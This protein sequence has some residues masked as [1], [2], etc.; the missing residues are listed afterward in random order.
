M[1][2]TLERVDTLLKNGQCEQSLQERLRPD[3]DVFRS[4]QHYSVGA[5]QLALKHAQ[6]AYDC[7]PPECLCERGYATLMLALARQMTGDL[8]QARQMVYEGLE[9]ETRH[10]PSYQGRLLWTLCFLQ[11]I[12]ADVTTLR[13]TSTT[14]LQLGMAHSL[15]ETVAY[16]RYFQGAAFY[17]SNHLAEAEASL[18]PVVVDRVCP[19]IASFLRS[20]C[21]LSLVRQAQGHPDEA[22]ELIESA[23]NQLLEQ[24]N[25]SSLDLAQ[26][27]EAEL[28]LRQGRLAEAL[29]WVETVETDHPPVGFEFFVPKL[30]VANILLHQ[31]TETSLEHA[32]E[33][34]AGMRQFFTEIHNTRFLIDVL[35]VQS[36]LHDIQGDDAAA[37]RS[38]SESLRLAE[39]GGFIRLFVD[40]GP[41]MANLL[42]RLMQQGVA[43]RYI[44]QLLKAFSDEEQRTGHHASQ[45]PIEPSSSEPSQSVLDGLTKREFEVLRLLAQRLSNQEIADTLFISS[46]TVKT[47]LYKI[48]KKLDAHGRRQA[49]AK[50]RS[51]GF[52]DTTHP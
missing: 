3:V 14:M 35:A 16:A 37:L 6:Q 32:G 44:G 11:W 33:L 1:F 47:H 36:L 46:R 23:I 50:A 26:A 51:L 39:P 52:F 42:E 29:R 49:V 25:S 21:A 24:G 8:R 7:L 40:L 48:Y 17:H 12:A 43:T 19:S 41:G 13:Q 28:A 31:G 18:R 38:L 34:L 15:P 22:R 10:S 45:H 2:Q 30:A 27:F 9:H 20:T 5:G 4:Y